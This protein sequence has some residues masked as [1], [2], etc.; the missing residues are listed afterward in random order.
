MEIKEF[1]ELGLRV[2]DIAKGLIDLSKNAYTPYSKFGVAACIIDSQGNLHYG[3]NCE[4]AN[5]DGTC[6]ET[7]AVG[8]YVFGGRKG[9]KTIVVYGAS[10]EGEPI[11]G[12]FTTPCGRCRQRLFEHATP[13][14]QVIC[15]EQTGERAQVF[16]M[17]ELIPYPFGPEDLGLSK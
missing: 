7:M 12:A 3:V 4:T 16:T 5:Y 1:K 8:N 13:D 15:I 11:S 9:I 6:A 17:G 14:A 10:I 2:R